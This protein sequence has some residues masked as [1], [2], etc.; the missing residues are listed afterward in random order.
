MLCQLIL[1]NGFCTNADLP[2][3]EKL[4]VTAPQAK[5]LTGPLKPVQ[6]SEFGAPGKLLAGGSVFLVKGWSRSVCA[7]AILLAAY[8]EPSLLEARAACV[9]KMI[10]RSAQALPEVVT[11][12]LAG[13]VGC[14]PCLQ[15]H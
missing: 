14:S 4:C 11:Q 15:A 1:V 5:W 10:F 13:N 12:I 8:E 9:A 6:P 7:V 2:G 3:V